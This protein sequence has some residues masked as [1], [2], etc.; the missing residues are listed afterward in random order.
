MNIAALSFGLGTIIFASIAKATPEE[1]I[2]KI[3][4]LVNEDAVDDGNDILSKMQ[5]KMTG[6]AKKSETERLLDSQ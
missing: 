4:T 2:A 3:P 1:L 5:N 6:K